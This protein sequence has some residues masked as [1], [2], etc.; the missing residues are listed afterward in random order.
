MRAASLLSGPPP[1]I[2]SLLNFNDFASESLG[3]HTSHRLRYFCRASGRCVGRADLGS[4]VG[5]CRLALAAVPFG[6]P[7]VSDGET[8]SSASTRRLGRRDRDCRAV[9]DGARNEHRP[10]GLARIE[11]ERPRLPLVKNPSS[12]ISP[13]A[14]S[15]HPSRASTRS[16]WWIQDLSAPLRAR[17][18]TS[19]GVR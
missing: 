7:L 9:A 16:R 8:F 4:V 19:V 15:A 13:A 17:W 1:P 5:G 3:H 2:R 14:V 6:Q 11:K 12:C 18:T 10:Q